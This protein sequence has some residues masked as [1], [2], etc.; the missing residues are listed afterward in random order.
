MKKEL[1]IREQFR[2]YELDFE[3]KLKIEYLVMGTDTLF[4]KLEINIYHHGN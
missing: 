4:F 2:E 3:K 1:T